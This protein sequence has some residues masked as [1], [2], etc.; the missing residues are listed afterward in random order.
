M[1]R[2]EFKAI[3]AEGL[4]P[5]QQRPLQKCPTGS[6]GHLSG[7]VSCPGAGTGSVRGRSPSRRVCRPGCVCVHS[8]IFSSL[9]NTESSGSKFRASF[10]AAVRS[11]E[12]IPREGAARGAV[13]PSAHRS[14][15]RADDGPGAQR[16]SCGRSG[17][18]HPPSVQP[19]PGGGRGPLLCLLPD[20]GPST[21]LPAYSLAFSVVRGPPTLAICFL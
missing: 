1:P 14:K 4:Y 21:S 7:A 3:A 16:C 6:R 10:Q 9:G 13:G 5:P 12:N 8:A 11:S 19:R 2:G 15:H 18:P 17:A 20:P